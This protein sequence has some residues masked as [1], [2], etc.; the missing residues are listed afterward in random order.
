M[1]KPVLC[2]V[3]TGGMGQQAHLANYAQL[4]DAGKCEIAG[5]VDLQRDLAEAVAAKYGVPQVY[6]DLDTALA[7]SRVTGVVCVQQWPNNYPL[8]KHILL[9]GKSVLTEKPMVG[10]LEEAEELV[11]LAAERGVLYAVGFMKRY[12]PGVELAKRLM[13]QALVSEELG[14]LRSVDAWC[15]G[16]DWRQN[17]GAPI[18]APSSTPLPSLVPTY[19]E[20]CRTPQQR[21]AYGYLLN[22]FSHNV[23]LCHHLLGTEL[24]PRAAAFHGSTA[25]LV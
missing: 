10:R 2:F 12:D 14:P 9:A 7:D 4:R 8:V 23:N 19:P 3:G 22:I 24:E 5:V 13:D 1:T 20:A 16:G 11:A 21:E 18:R 15:N 17:V 25:M 6:A